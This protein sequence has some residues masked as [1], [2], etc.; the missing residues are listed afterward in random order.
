MTPPPAASTTGRTER[1]LLALYC[2][3]FGFGGVMHL[4][5]VVS[6]GPLPYTEDP[7]VWNVFMTSLA[8]L[9]PLTVVLLLTRRRAGLALAVALVALIL[10]MNLSLTVKQ[11]LEQGTFFHQWLYLNGT[12]S[13]LVLATARRL[14]RTAPRP[15][16]AAGVLPTQAS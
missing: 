6:L 16:G 3:G 1:V 9:N 7:L 14:W 5:D 13:A 11:L 10:L 15:Q 4:I 12:F 2:L 8:A